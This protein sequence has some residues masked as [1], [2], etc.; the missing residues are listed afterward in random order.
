MRVAAGPTQRR[1][2]PVA[3]VPTRPKLEAKQRAAAKA[4]V[5]QACAWAEVSAGG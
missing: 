2:R 3:T 1:E 4:N 5:E